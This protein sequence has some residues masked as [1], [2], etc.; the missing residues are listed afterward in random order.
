MTA[1]SPTTRVT[2]NGIKLDDGYRTLITFARAPDIAFWEKTVKPPGLDGGDPI[3][4]T[5]MWNTRWRTMKTRQLITMS[6]GTAKV[7]Y[8]PKLYTTILSILNQPDTVTYRFPD[9]STVAVYAALQKFEPDDL[10]EGSQPEA[11]ITIL[12]MNQDADGV[13]TDPAVAEVAGT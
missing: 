3:N 6:E 8:D 9:G 1:P 2:P 11:T 12:M 5:T 4:T 7:A 13:E 10:E